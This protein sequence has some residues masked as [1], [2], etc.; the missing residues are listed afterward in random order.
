[1]ARKVV[2]CPLEAEKLEWLEVYMKKQGL[3]YRKELAEM[4]GIARSTLDGIFNGGN[5]S[6]RIRRT[7]EDFINFAKIEED[8]QNTGSFPYSEFEELPDLNI[9]G[10]EVP[11]YD[12]VQRARIIAF[13][14]AGSSVLK[15]ALVLLANAD[16]GT[17]REILEEIGETVSGLYPLSRALQSETMRERVLSELG[18]SSFS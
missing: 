7:I 13:I 3:K 5:V 16:V 10:D 4:M 17:R 15:P 12:E 11:A 8:R 9:T 6:R 18:Q 1:M 14:Q 2:E